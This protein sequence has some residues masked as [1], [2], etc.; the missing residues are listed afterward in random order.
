MP[1][2]SSGSGGKLRRKPWSLSLVW[3]IPAV[4]AL[5]S[6]TLLV[7]TLSSRG[8]TVAV[9][10]RTADGLTPGR[11][12]V[13]YKSVDV[14]VV[15]AVRLSLDHSKV[16]AS[17]TL[18]HDA[19]AFARQGSTFW[20]VRPRVSASGVTGLETLLSGAYI[21]VDPAKQGARQ[22][23]FEG[24]N[25]PPIFTSDTAGKQFVLRADDL[26]S[27][28]AG[29]PVYFRRIQVGEVVGYQLSA[30]GRDVLV[31]VFVRDP[32]ARFVTVDTRFWHASGVD[33]QLDAKGVQLNMQSLATILQGGV[34]F[35]SPGDERLVL[36]A[37]ENAEFALARDESGALKARDEGAPV[38]AL[39]NF[40]QSVRGLSP[41]APVEFRGI[42]VGKVRSIGIEFRRETKTFRMPVIVELYP[43]RIGINRRD[44]SDKA[45]GQAMAEALNTQGLRAQ[46]RTGNLLTGQLFVSFEFFPNAP[47]AALHLVGPLPELPTV[48]GSLDELQAK[49][50]NI[51]T[52]LDQV[53]F[54]QIGKELDRALRSADRVINTT[55]SVA[56]QLD[57]DI[58]PQVAQSIGE[59]RNTLQSVNRAL[60][61]E[62]GMEADARRTMQAFTAAARSLRE[63]ADSLKNHPESLIRGKPDGEGR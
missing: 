1:N 50:G 18:T 40:D 15:S 4:A 52:K 56:A 23:E 55:G 41:G 8:P 14:G 20:V 47:P 9:A 53:P 10:F 57:G 11:T 2:H 32:Y 49:I 36:Q 54:D 6:I 60:D 63:L 27:L 46:L 33:L 29:S 45:Y 16:I 39:L 44:L 43:S 3:A 48:P 30:D 21:G 19:E 62:D 59:A 25:A 51:V 61:P 28:D 38:L 7:Q 42:P 24:L 12:A 22:L 17:I 58:L 35:R 26:G 13:R 34:A 37:E 31:R 5:V